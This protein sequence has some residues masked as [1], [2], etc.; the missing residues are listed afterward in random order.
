M[1]RYRNQHQ[2]VFFVDVDTNLVHV[3]CRLAGHC[4][5]KAESLRG[6]ETL[7]SAREL[8]AQLCPSCIGLF[9]S[10]HPRL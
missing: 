7:D 3:G 9:W 4:N 8:G 6:I 1:P 2:C 5:S 10:S